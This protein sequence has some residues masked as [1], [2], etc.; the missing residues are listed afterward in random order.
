MVLRLEYLQKYLQIL[1][2]VE[3]EERRHLS[4]VEVK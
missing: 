3:A 4:Y 1:L 2:D